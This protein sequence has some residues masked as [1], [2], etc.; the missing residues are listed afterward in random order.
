MS[1]YKAA[2]E[3]RLVKR[4]YLWY[5]SI[6]QIAVSKALIN[7]Q[8][9]FYR[10]HLMQYLYLLMARISSAVVGKHFI[11]LQHIKMLET[12]EKSNGKIVS[13]EAAG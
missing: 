2:L 8:I 6:F 13:E 12:V 3:S 1:S 10:N 11:R 7:F 5:K 4:I 9:N